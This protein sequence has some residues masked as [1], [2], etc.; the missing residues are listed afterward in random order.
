MPGNQ[1]ALCTVFKMRQTIS[2]CAE[3]LDVCNL[4]MLNSQASC[5][6]VGLPG[7]LCRAIK[8]PADRLSISCRTSCRSCRAQLRS[9]T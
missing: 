4:P 8:D 1:A 5:M 6:H 7:T 3:E 2:Q 9:L